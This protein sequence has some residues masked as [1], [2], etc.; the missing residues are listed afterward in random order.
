MSHPAALR[1]TQVCSQIDALL[2]ELTRLVA[3]FD[4]ERGYVL[5]GSANTVAWLRVHG[6]MSVPMAMHVMSAA[7]QLPRLPEVERA[8]SSGV[9][10]FEHAAAIAES[11]DKL[12]ADSLFSRQAE[13]VQKAEQVDPG[14]FRNEV[15]KVEHQL[16]SE[17]MRREAQRAFESRR[18]EVR[19]KSDGRVEVEG[20]LD[21]E[22]GVVLKKA[23]EAAMGPRSQDEPRSER[24][25]RADGLV[26][27]ARRCL[28]GRQLGETGC[29]RPHVSAF[30]EPDGQG[31]VEGLG[32]V[33]AETIER[34]LCD[35]S[36][37]VNGSPRVRTFSPAKRRALM[38]KG[39]TCHFPGCDRPADWCDGHHV[40][41]Y[42]EGGETV[43]SN[44]ALVCHFHHRL[45]HE[46]GW[47][48][49]RRDQELVVFRPDGAR[50][51]SSPAPPAP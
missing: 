45:V 24:Q 14:V 41:H 10:G 36:L 25:R 46:G 16:D 9:I 2:V 11:A 6:R 42:R 5:D 51:R 28:D 39:R 33:A 1:L 32:P 37:S 35:C 43:P 18:L 15:K 23:L 19:T 8:V 31:H 4:R 22:G 29:Q 26:D 17:L 13:L 7:R 38:R 21:P 27:L 40:R 3:A 48:M 12:G 20:L 34:L 47:R 44:G 50:Y 30:V 49:E